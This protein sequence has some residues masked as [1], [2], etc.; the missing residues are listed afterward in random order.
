MTSSEYKNTIEW[1]LRRA[2]ESD[3]LST[4]K[5]ILRNL[6][7][8]FPQGN[9]EN[10]VNLLS[11]GNYM[12]WNPCN[13]EQA[14]FC[15]NNGYPAVA[16]AD[17][18]V[19][20]LLPDDESVKISSTVANSVSKLA[21]KVS[22]L[23]DSKEGK[24]GFFVFATLLDNG[25]DDANGNNMIAAY[26][27][28]TT[29]DSGCQVNCQTAC[30]STCQTG[31]QVN[32]QNSCETGCMTTCQTSCQ[33][34]NT[35]QST[36]QT[37][38]QSCNVCD[39]CQSGCQ[40]SCQTGCQVNCQNSC[41][42]GCMSSCEL[43]CQ[44]CDT[45]Q[46]TCE[47]SCQ[48]CNV[49]DD[50]Q[51]G[52]QVNCQNSCETGCM[53]T[54][55]TSCQSCNTCQ[56]TCES[57]CQDTCESSC[58]S[59]NT[60]Q[61]TCESVCQDTCESSCQS[62]NTC[63]STCESVC[64]SVCLSSCQD[65]CQ[66]CEGCDTC[67]SSQNV[68]ASVC[69]S[70]CLSSC[71]DTCQTCE[72]C[73]TCDSSQN[74][75]ESVCQS[76]EGCDTCNSGQNVC[77]SICQNVNS[78]TP[79][80]PTVTLSAPSDDCKI[81]R[82]GR[83]AISA[84]GTDCAT[85]EIFINDASVNAKSGNSISFIYGFGTEGRYIVYA[86]GTSGTGHTAVSECRTIIVGNPPCTL[87]Y[88][89]NGGAGEAPDAQTFKPGEAVTLAALTNPRDYYKLDYIFDGW[90]TAADGSGTLFHSGEAVTFTEDVTLYAQFTYAFDPGFVREED[91]A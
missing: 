40:V 52:C 39:D 71:Q 9:V 62:C 57:V 45:C 11:S 83:V 6:G 8:P 54:C 29:C 3:D 67:D 80:Y 37:S 20:I 30:Q 86:K 75:C 38:C 66:T 77:E 5:R 2:E 32:C 85:I 7:T 19:V 82:N 51:S 59:C 60:C 35:C 15:V 46:S 23:D 79:I 34:C 56:S 55:Q 36:C 72:G 90:N 4:V 43:S 13:K 89:I 1:T 25:K 91:D 73:D 65:T 58:Q 68:C 76:C 18:T 26:S 47:T 78:T 74:V 53:T 88:N 64:Q 33:S 10:I 61:N 87:T 22:E 81:E 14:R 63:Q 12:G 44:S 27:T 28:D 21:R 69:Q 49:C 31:C 48:S 84:S 16:V 50:C 41:E 42:T 24:T 70:V 17:G